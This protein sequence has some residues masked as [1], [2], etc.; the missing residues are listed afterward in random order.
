MSNSKEEALKN[1]E[2]KINVL[3]SW[4]SNDIPFRCDVDGHPILDNKDN[5]TIDYVPTTVRQFLGWN[6]TQNCESVKK[7]LPAIRSLNNTTLF[8][9]KNHRI[10]VENLVTALK[11]KAKLQQQRTSMSEIKRYKSAQREM[12]IN[13]N[14]LVKENLLLRRD[15]IVIETKFKE[16]LRGTQGHEQESATNFLILEKEI[17]R[18]NAQVSGLT[19]TLKKLKPLSITRDANK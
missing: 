10:E 15:N 11:E 12:E 18:L 13:I 19:K 6:G 4:L 14:S 16:L 9:H 3:K 7:G 8:N 5:K 1:I 2:L 17:E